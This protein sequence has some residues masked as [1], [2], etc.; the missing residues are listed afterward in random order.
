MVEEGKAR[1]KQ[2]RVKRHQTNLMTP[3]EDFTQ[4]Q[5]NLYYLSRVPEAGC[6]GR[7]MAARLSEDKATLLLRLPHCVAESG[8]TRKISKI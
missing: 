2:E 4:D 5:I 3:C 7:R 1:D 8:S 6:R